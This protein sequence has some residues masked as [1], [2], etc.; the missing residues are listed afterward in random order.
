MLHLDIMERI[1]S[2]SIVYDSHKFW[3]IL[4]YTCQYTTQNQI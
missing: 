4:D 1:P 3:I 2:T